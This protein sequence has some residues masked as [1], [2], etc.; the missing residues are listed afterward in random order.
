MASK[1]TQL[2]RS[3]ADYQSY[4]CF[5][6]S[7]DHDFPSGS[8]WEIE[9]AIY[10]RV[11]HIPLETIELKECL[12]S[13]VFTSKLEQASEKL[14][15]AGVWE[16]FCQTIEKAYRERTKKYWFTLE[17]TNQTGLFAAVL[18]TIGDLDL[19]RG[20]ASLVAVVEPDEEKE[21]VE[22]SHSPFV[23]RGRPVKLI[24]RPIPSSPTP[25]SPSRLTT[26]MARMSLWSND[27]TSK[28]FTGLQPGLDSM[29]S[30]VTNY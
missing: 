17:E 27:G 8:K 18:E 5:L 6:S 3:V 22:V 24:S 7:P 30:S 10:L 28:P 14:R 23:Q 20:P 19:P 15:N 16:R 9:H 29:T 4:H 11:L 13:P 2:P 1:P 26:G 25:S 12:K 21:K